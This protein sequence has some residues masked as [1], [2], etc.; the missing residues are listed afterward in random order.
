MNTRIGWTLIIA[1]VCLLLTS[2][3]ALAQDTDF[4]VQLTQNEDGLFEFKKVFEVPGSADDLYQRANRWIVHAYR[5]A[6][7]VIQLEDPDN[8]I[9]MARGFS[10]GRV[11]LTKVNMWHILQIDTKDGRYRV[12][13]S[14][15]AYSDP[16]GVV[17]SGR[18]I[19]LEEERGA[20]KK[21]KKK[22]EAYI[23][24]AL[25]GLAKAMTKTDDW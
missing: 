7:H 18:E 19:H 15:F 1:F 8:H 16:K 3:A 6:N 13:Y 22:I 4:K 14:S 11:V 10:E 25:A 20:S 24:V 23:K 17:W 21:V 12:S 2:Y 5:S 9:I